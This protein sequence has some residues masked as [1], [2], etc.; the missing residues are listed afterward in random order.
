MV[1]PLHPAAGARPRA[2]T[3]PRQSAILLYVYRFRAILRTEGSHEERVEQIRFR[4][5]P[6][7]SLLSLERIASRPNRL[8]DFECGTKNSRLLT[9]PAWENVWDRIHCYSAPVR[10]RSMENLSGSAGGCEP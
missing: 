9:S 7:R 6:L 8:I 10:L 3:A 1:W 4:L 2:L 5:L